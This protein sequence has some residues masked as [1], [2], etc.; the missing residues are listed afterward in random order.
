MQ[1]YAHII[2]A[3]VRLF[4]ADTLKVVAERN[5]ADLPPGT[6][7]NAR[8]KDW[9][10]VLEVEVLTIQERSEVIKVKRNDT[11]MIISSEHYD[12]SG[13]VNL[14]TDQHGFNSMVYMTPEEAREVV[15]AL[16]LALAKIA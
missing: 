1:V 2:D 8:I 15:M 16:N 3:A 14:Y 11:Y 13:R 6:D 10:D 4:N 9:A 5:I 7:I 12:G